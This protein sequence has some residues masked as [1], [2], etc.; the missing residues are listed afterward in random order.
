MFNKDCIFHINLNFNLILV[1]SPCNGEGGHAE[2]IQEAFVLFEDDVED[3]MLIKY[4]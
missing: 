4:I 1:P 2:V 3:E